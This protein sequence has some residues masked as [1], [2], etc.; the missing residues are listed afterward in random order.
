MDF[1]P[2]LWATPCL[3]NHRHT[4]TNQIYFLREIFLFNELN[5]IYTKYVYS[6]LQLYKDEIVFE[7]FEGDGSKLLFTFN[8]KILFTNLFLY[9]NTLSYWK[10]TFHTVQFDHC[11]PFPSPSQ[12]LLN[13]HPPKFISFLL[14]LRRTQRS[15]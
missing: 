14:S 6:T 9:E 2:S 8:F 1:C 3:I 15:I 13:S 10:F 11:F 12:I 7:L 4:F 5:S